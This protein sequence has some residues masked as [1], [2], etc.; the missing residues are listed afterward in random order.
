MAKLQ[1]VSDAEFAREV[2][3]TPGVVAVDFWAPWCGPCRITKPMLEELAER[4]AGSARVLAL[5]TDLNPA[6]TIALG[7]R[8]MPTLVIFRDGAEVARIVGAVP[9]PMLERRFQ[10]AVAGA[11]VS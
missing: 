5:D 7:V 4:Y 10:E 8:S 11:Q 3:E 2:K 6:T 9:K 1:T